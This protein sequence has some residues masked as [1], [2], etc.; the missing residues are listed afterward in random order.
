MLAIGVDIEDNSRFEG[1]TLENSANFLNK[2]FTLSE[3]EYCF[4]NRLP[5][6]HL[7]ARFCA[8]EAVVKAFSNI[9]NKLIPYSK[10]EILK[11]YNG[12]VYVNILIDE[13]KKYKILL[14]I[15][16]EKDKSIAFVVIEW[17]FRIIKSKGEINMYNVFV[18]KNGS[19]NAD[20]AGEF[21]NINDAIKLAAELKSKDETISYT[22][23]E[24][25]GHFD[26]YGEPLTTVVKR[27]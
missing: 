21:S 2:I 8:K 15:S 5:A 1:K 7:C 3:L 4:K 19:Y 24:T 16:H 11:N 12:S 6:P 22:I 26:S 23:E 20:L 14:S 9:Y 13:L 27:G 10:I 18:K 17:Y 25:S